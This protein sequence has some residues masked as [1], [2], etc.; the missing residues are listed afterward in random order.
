M[1][2]SNWIKSI[3]IVL[4]LL[5]STPAYAME[6]FDIIT[7]EELEQMLAARG[8]GD[9]DFVLANSLDEIIFLNASIPGSINIPWSRIDETV[10]RLGEDKD[11]RIIF[12]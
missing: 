4:G 1:D 8:R 5:V 7:T 6:R 9:L 3:I 2:T 12:Y 11:K 10:H